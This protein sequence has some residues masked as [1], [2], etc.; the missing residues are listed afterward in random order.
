MYESAERGKYRER[1]R[2]RNEE[3]FIWMKSQI[4]SQDL[5]WNAESYL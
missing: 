2:E 5:L 1:K 3:P 4:E